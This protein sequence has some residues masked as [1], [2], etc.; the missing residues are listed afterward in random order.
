MTDLYLIEKR[1]LYYRPNAQGYTCF[2]HEAGTYT[3]D[4]VAE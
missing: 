3:L 1:G 4:E 2:K